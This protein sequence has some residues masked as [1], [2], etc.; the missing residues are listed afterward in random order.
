[1]SSGKTIEARARPSHLHN[2]L[3]REAT[4]A[5]VPGMA[6]VRAGD[7]E[8]EEYW[9]ERI[10][11]YLTGQLQPQKAL[12]PRVAFVSI[13][14]NLVAGFIAGHLTQRF[15]C[16]GELEWISIRPQYRRRGVASSLL[17][18]L[19]G[20]FRDQGA[21]RICVDVEPSNADARAFYSAH[22]AVDL[23]P[24]WMVWE[25]IRKLA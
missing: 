15:G 6:Q 1:M 16:D 8:S 4:L 7:W 25:D 13:D 21:G 20:W 18:R 17:R 24:H 5:D 2:M 19:A 23:K 11:P 9:R 10:P 22:G 14:D 3:Y 12:A